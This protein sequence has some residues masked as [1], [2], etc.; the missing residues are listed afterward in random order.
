METSEI[1]KYLLHISLP[2]FNGEVNI[3]NL[4][5]IHKNH[6]YR[7]P[8][9]NLDIHLN[10][11]IITDK[12]SLF[13]KIIHKMRGGFCYELN[14]LFYELL[15]SIGYK[16][17]MISAGVYND[18]GLPGQEFDH[19]ALI[20]YTG[21]KELLC[22]VG[23]GDSFIEPLEFIPGRE[24]EDNGGIFK[25]TA[26]NNDDYILRRRDDK[27][28]FRNLYVFSLKQRALDDF[29]QMCVYHPDI[30][31]FNF[32]TKT[33]LHFSIPERTLHTARQQIHYY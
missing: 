8:F 14:G 25:I 24:Q 23:F 5:R 7:I 9:E 33:V 2:D 26:I 12:N 1:K 6:L 27:Y 4:K 13:D 28:G 17:K 21:G 29:E 3:D 22:D 18:D 11:K 30:S 10:K 32:Y 31:R 19:M 16:V 15:T 20:V